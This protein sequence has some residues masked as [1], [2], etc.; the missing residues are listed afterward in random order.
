MNPYE[1][2]GRAPSPKVR[3]PAV[4]GGRTAPHTEA[5]LSTLLDLLTG[6]RARVR[7]VAVGHARD[8]A[9]RA[10]AEAFATA[11]QDMAGDVVAVV[12]WPEEAAS[13]L[14]AARRLT[15]GAPDAWVLSGA[16]LGVA[17]LLRRLRH[18]TDWDPARTYCFAGLGTPE[19]VRLAGAETVDG[20]RGAAADGGKW[21]MRRGWLTHF[22]PHAGAEES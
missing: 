21:E 19:V 13:W 3:P 18:S 14:R 15:A 20:L 9:A 22:A 16:P 7:T 6:G 2:A 10:A 12:D 5:E 8:P 17:Q 1:E 4:T 11:W